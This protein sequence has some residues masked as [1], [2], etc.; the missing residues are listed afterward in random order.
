MGSRAGLRV[1]VDD[2]L[3]HLVLDSPPV[4]R[5][6]E[7]FLHAIGDAVRGLPTDLRA[8]VVSSSVERI[9][10]AGGDL[11]WM[12]VAPLEEQLRFVDLCQSTY[13]LFEEV[14][15]PV[16]AA[17]EGAALGGGLELA[18][19][20]DIRILGADARIGLPE[21]TIGL[22]AGAG[23][24]TRLVRAIGRGVAHDL[25]LPGRRLSADEALAMGIASRATP[26]GEAVAAALALARTLAD[27][28]TEAIQATKRLA[29]V[30]GEGTI[31]DGLRRER[32]AWAIV[33]RS[34]TTQEGLEAF[35]SK[36]TPDFP[37]AARRDA[38]RQSAGDG[39]A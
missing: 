11:H 15:Y 5:F 1:N 13:S 38:A 36:R 29:V 28:P 32:Q 26:A 3:G 30:A 21:A 10:A 9:F 22:L 31:A 34:A 6:D 23:G 24:I 7:P 16:V 25:L 33:R 12:A 39:P 2:G 19:A 14:P 37:A 20:C 35:A 27:G 4:N 17:I 18:L 8:L